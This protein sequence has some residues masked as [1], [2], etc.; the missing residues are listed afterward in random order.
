MCIE[1]TAMIVQRVLTS[2]TV[3]FRSTAAAFSTDSSR[4]S[5]SSSADETELRLRRLGD[6]EETEL[7]L[8]MLPNFEPSC[9]VPSEHRIAA[10]SV[11]VAL[12]A[13][14]FWSFFRNSSVLRSQ[15]LCSAPGLRRT[16]RCQVYGWRGI[17]AM[18]AI[19]GGGGKRETG[20]GGGIEIG[21]V[22]AS[23]NIGGG[24]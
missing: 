7:K 8:T 13:T 2:H 22:H 17:G 23:G 9:S 3:A 10:E 20:S 21:V 24:G 11:S 12:T 16:F 15:S 14:G 19:D 6:S 5:S 18:D 4:A 1:S